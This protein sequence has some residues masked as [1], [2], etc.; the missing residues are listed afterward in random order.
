MMIPFG[1]PQKRENPISLGANRFLINKGLESQKRQRQRGK[2]R[3]FDL[4]PWILVAGK[5]KAAV[6]HCLILSAYALFF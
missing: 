4:D 6:S 2:E 5:S 1:G 3:I